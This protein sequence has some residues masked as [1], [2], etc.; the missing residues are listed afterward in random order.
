MDGGGRVVY[1]L[2]V[3][4][5][6]VSMEVLFVSVLPR[7]YRRV[8]RL[9]FEF[10]AGIHVPRHFGSFAVLLFFF[11]T[12]LY[13]LSSSGHMGMIVKAVVADTG[14]V[15]ADVDINGN[16][17]LV[18]QEV[19]K[20]LGLDTA[21]SIFTFDVDRAR[22]LLEQQAWVQSANIQKI[23]PNRVR[24]SV[25]EREPYAIWQHDGVMDIIDDTGRVILPFKGGIVQG[26]PLVVGQGA[27]NA[28]KMFLQELSVY[29]QLYSRA[30][31][32]VRVGERRWDLVLD[33][34]VRIML[35]EK[36]ALERLSSL[37]KTE[38]AQDLFSRD[39]LSLDLRLSDR[40]TVSLSDEAL[41][42]RAAVVAEEEPILKARK[43]GSL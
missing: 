42:R 18:K 26:L 36:G 23:Y 39:I 14:F 2:N 5:T 9:M 3:N 16:K 29:P 41:E 35:P 15:I 37:L 38:L 7:L 25:V 21:A 43:A 20:I 24:I 10:I 40:I 32:F 31:A 13:G 1:A 28:A 19:L 12:V 30:R 6:D 33:N 17:R 27:Q 34:G 22:F 8:L 4:K 11:F